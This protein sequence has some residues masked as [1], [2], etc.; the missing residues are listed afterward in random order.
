M[1]EP[2]LPRKGKDQVV[3][4]QVRHLVFGLVAVGAMLALISLGGKVIIERGRI[5]RQQD[6]LDGAQA[7]LG[8]IQQLRQEGGLKWPAKSGSPSPTSHSAR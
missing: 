8:M 3:D 2:R 1:P 6:L 4:V 5:R 7:L